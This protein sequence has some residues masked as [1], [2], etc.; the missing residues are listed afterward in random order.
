MYVTKHLPDE[1]SLES[2]VKQSL[3]FKVIEI[4]HAKSSLFFVQLKVIAEAEAVGNYGV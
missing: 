4:N 3:S 1:S 2:C